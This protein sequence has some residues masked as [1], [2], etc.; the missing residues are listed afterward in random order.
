MQKKFTVSNQLGKRRS[1]MDQPLEV[2]LAIIGRARVKKVPIPLEEMPI[3]DLMERRVF[4]TIFSFYDYADKV[5]ELFQ[6]LDKNS[7]KHFRSIHF[8]NTAKFLKKHRWHPYSWIPV[9]LKE[10]DIWISEIQKFRKKDT[11]RLPIPEEIILSEWSN[12]Q[13]KTL[14]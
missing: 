12:P 3:E 8:K 13:T 6:I 5:V 4:Y 7:R 9:S 14:D 10:D 1:L 11:W 2:R